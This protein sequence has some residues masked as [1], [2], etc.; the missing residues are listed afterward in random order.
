MDADGQH[1]VVD[2]AYHLLDTYWNYEIW[3]TTVSECSARS[4]SHELYTPASLT[5]SLPSYGGVSTQSQALVN[6]I[7]AVLNLT[8]SAKV[9][10]LPVAGH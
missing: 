10:V 7:Y 4:Q 9:A 2:L 6:Q 8:G 5:L 1:L 3:D